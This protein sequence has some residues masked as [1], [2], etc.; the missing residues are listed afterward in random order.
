MA[1]VALKGKAESLSPYKILGHK[2]AADTFRHLRGRKARFIGREREIDEPVRAVRD[3]LAGKGAVI[4]ISGDAGSGK[5]RLVSEFKARVKAMGCFGWREAFAYPH[6]QNIA[7]SLW[8]DF[9]N[10]HLSSSS[11]PFSATW[12]TTRS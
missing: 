2:K 4:S 3:Q 1:P 5:S 8:I 11:T 10:R 7:Y 6:A 9:I 12:C